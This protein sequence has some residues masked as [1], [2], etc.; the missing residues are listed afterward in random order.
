MVVPETLISPS[1]PPQPSS[2]VVLDEL[3]RGTSTHDGYALAAAVTGWLTGTPR[4]RLLF[5]THYHGLAREEDLL[6]RGVQLAH[7][8]SAVDALGLVPL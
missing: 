2:L 3:G 4:C 1:P 8:A 5:A 7:M 6:R